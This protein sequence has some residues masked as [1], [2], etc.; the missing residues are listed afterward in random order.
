VAQGVAVSIA[1]R[2]FHLFLSLCYDV[3]TLDRIRWGEIMMD[4]IKE[5]R[6][7]PGIEIRPNSKE[8]EYFEAVINK[9]DL[10]LL[11]SLLRKHLGPAAKEPGKEAKLP[12]EIQR[13]VNAGGGL[14][15]EQSFFYRKED[16]QVIFATLWPWVSNPNKITLK[17][18]IWKLNPAN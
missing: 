11:L 16:K 18:G 17:S 8:P 14:R 15:I 13:G 5:V 4:M 9:G 7:I 3:V 6:R 12:I 1:R 10:E 2:T